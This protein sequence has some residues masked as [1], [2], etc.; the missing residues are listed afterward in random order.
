[1]S[2]QPEPMDFKSIVVQL[3]V[4]V[5]NSIP[6]EITKESINP[7]KGAKI[8]L[9]GASRNLKWKHNDKGITVAVPES[10]RNNPVSKYAWTFKVSAVN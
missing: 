10:L 1:M 3:A 9:L 7:K 5:E 2:H 4:E 8:K 6:S